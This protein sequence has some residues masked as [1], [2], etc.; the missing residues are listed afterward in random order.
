MRQTS[1]IM[2]LEKGGGCNGRCPLCHVWQ[3]TNSN[4]TE[5]THSFRMKDDCVAYGVPTFPL[6]AEWILKTAGALD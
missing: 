1:I 2:P 3:M 6:G 5:A 4:R